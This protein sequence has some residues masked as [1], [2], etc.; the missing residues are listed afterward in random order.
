MDISTNLLGYLFASL[1]AP[2]LASWLVWR[3]RRRL[4]WAVRVMEW[5]FD[6]GVGR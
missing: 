5:V 3:F 6:V 1:I 2:P 4:G